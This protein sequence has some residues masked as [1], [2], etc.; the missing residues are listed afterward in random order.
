MGLYKGTVISVATALLLGAT[1]VVVAWEPDPDEP[2]RSTEELRVLSAAHE[3]GCAGPPEK[4]IYPKVVSTHN[5]P[6]CSS[7]GLPAGSRS[8][9]SRS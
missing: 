2:L 4:S 5:R 1:L 3:F 8:R 6:S 7:T 9:D